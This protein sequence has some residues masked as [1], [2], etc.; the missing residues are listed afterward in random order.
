MPSSP[1]PNSLSR[2]AAVV[3]VRMQ[4]AS[5]GQGLPRP[6]MVKTAAEIARQEGV[7]GFT[8]A[9]SPMLGVAVL[10]TANLCSSIALHDSAVQMYCRLCMWY[11]LAGLTGLS[12][13][14]RKH[15]VRLVHAG[16][17]ASC[18]ARCQLR[19]SAAG[20]VPA[21]QDSR[22]GGGRFDHLG[23]DSVWRPGEWTRTSCGSVKHPIRIVTRNADQ[24][25]PT[26]LLRV[27]KRATGPTHDAASPSLLQAGMIAGAASNPI[28][29]IKVRMQVT[30]T[31]LLSSPLQPQSTLPILYHTR[32]SSSHHDCPR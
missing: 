6:G 20:T 3:K 21:N 24:Y 2:P 7:L 28:D 1:Q 12:Y 23:Q 9:S 32:V 25:D 11:L 27:K 15:P 5:S 14:Y 17:A 16:V 4:L 8:K 10:S 29:L 26:Q 18:G 22:A 30:D 13:A 19:C 31:G